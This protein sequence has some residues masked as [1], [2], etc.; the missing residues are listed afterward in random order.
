MGDPA[1]ALPTLGWGSVAMSLVSLG[2]V[3]VLAYVALR[4]LAGRG[5]G[6]PTGAIQVLA[7]CPLEP[8]RSVYLIE[9]A[10][11]CFLVGVGDGPMSLLAE[12]DRATVAAAAAPG[13]SRVWRACSRPGPGERRRVAGRA[14]AARLAAL[15]VARARE[16]RGMNRPLRWSLLAMAALSLVPF[17]LLMTTCFVRVAVVLSILRSAIGTPQVPPT[18]VLT[19]LALILTLSV[20]AP[21]GE[22]MYRRGRAGAGARR[23]RRAR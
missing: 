20:M 5:V 11:R 22:R 8:R 17:A 4:W 14:R 12:V 23:R 10:G 7:R 15:R 19:G 2:V 1:G 13:D 3:C 16:P 6:R 21:T 9:T 18:Q